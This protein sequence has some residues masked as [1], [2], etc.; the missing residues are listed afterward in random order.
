MQQYD[1]I[2]T[3]N[4]SSLDYRTRDTLDQVHLKAD[5]TARAEHCMK[6]IS[7]NRGLHVHVL[8]NAAPLR[9][10]LTLGKKV[11]KLPW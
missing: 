4:G 1:N 7:Q 11:C 3:H 6:N 9:Y 5:T 2:S 10:K 8:P